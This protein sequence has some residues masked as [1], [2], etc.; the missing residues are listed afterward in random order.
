[1]WPEIVHEDAAARDGRDGGRRLAG[2]G[3]RAAARGEFLRIAAFVLLEPR[4]G[5]LELEMRVHGRS[6]AY[7]DADDGQREQQLVQDAPRL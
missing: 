1:V 7:G 5:L 4:L 2:I 3:E 6:N